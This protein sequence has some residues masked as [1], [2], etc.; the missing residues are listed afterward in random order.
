MKTT[1]HHNREF[2]GWSLH[3]AGLLVIAL[4]LATFYQLSYAPMV[5]QSEKH[6]KRA[7][8][9]EQLLTTSE[10]VRLKHQT[11]RQE[12]DDLEHETAAMRERLPH[13]LQKNQFESSLRIAARTAKFQ[14]EETNWNAPESTP[15]HSHT[16]VMVNGFGSFASICGF[17]DNVNQLARITK[18]SSMELATDQESES[19]PLQVT[20][21]LV[22]GIESN[23]TKKTGGVL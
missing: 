6:D 13:D 12:L 10:K 14:L 2:V 3:A 19:Y 16:E 1:K 4:V 8:Q 15:T 22:Y 11:L 17:L 21:V 5:V 9:L 23:D 20:F 18:I 7:E